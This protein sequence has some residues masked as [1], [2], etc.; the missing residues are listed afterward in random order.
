MSQNNKWGGSGFYDITPQNNSYIITNEHVCKNNFYMNVEDQEGK[1]FKAEVLFS[2]E[3]LDLCALK[4]TKQI[5][6]KL[7]KAYTDCGEYVIF[8]G[9]PLLQP[10][11]VQVTQ[12]CDRVA[13][14]TVKPGNSGSPV[15]NLD[16]ELVGVIDALFRDTNFGLIIHLNQIYSFLK[17]K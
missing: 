1:K 4:S 15:I 3:D 6:F 11:T 10:F 7:A 9:Y 17:G 2:S 16:G 12:L 5:G 14:T 8:M 13:L